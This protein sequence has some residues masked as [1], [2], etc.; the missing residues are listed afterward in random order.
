[1]DLKAYT[2]NNKEDFIYY[3]RDILILATKNIS[4]YE[5]KIKDLGNFIEGRNLIERPKRV[6]SSEIYED[7]RSM[8]GYTGNYLSNLFGDAAEYGCSYRNYR[9]NVKKK[10]KELEIEYITFTQE[11]ETNLNEITSAR[12]WGNHVPVSL[13]HSTK[14]KAFGEKIDT[15]IPI[16]VPIFEKYQGMWLVDLYNSNY[17]NLSRYKDVFKLVVEEYEKLIGNNCIIFEKSVP[18]RDMSD[19]I[20]PIISSGIQNKEI[21]TIE[22][23]QKIYQEEG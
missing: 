19:L 13:I 15:R 20:I 17:A 6:V 5:R 12:N 1:M 10:A 2:F 8:L 14:D 22:D 11:Q 23:I 9:K 18:V 21:K 3:L 7:Y 4:N 16:F